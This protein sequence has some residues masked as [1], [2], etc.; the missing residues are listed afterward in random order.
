MSLLDKKS[1][2]DRHQRDNLGNSVGEGWPNGF[3]GA[4]ENPSNG[5]YF[6]DSEAVAYSPF[7]PQGGPAHADFD[8]MVELLDKNVISNNSGVTYLHSPR[9][10]TPPGYFQ[11]LRPGD[12][13]FFSGQP[14]NPT[15]GQFGGPYINSVACT[16]QGGY[17]S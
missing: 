15:L 9:Y 6:I 16:Q 11:D 7:Q 4:G 5:A 12:T 1:L 13:D 14:V 8:H 10:G 2:Y 17:C 3:A